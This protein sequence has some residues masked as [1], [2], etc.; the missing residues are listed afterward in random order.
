MT[1]FLGRVLGGFALLA[2]LAAGAATTVRVKV[3]VLEAPPCV[4]NNN[5]TIEVDFGDVMTT[6]IDGISYAEPLKYGVT[7]T[8]VAGSTLN[9]QLK[10]QIGGTAAG[11]GFADNVLQTSVPGLGVAVARDGNPLTLD[12]WSSFTYPNLPVLTVTPVKLAGATLPGGEFTA[13][14]TMRV[15]YQ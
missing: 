13:S 5:Q 6:R 2:S 3:T 11:G 1:R 15:E 10:M 8:P 4:I 12:S 7:C 9:P 14:A